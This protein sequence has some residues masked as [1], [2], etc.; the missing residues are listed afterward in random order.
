M[1]VYKSRF[2]SRA[3]V[4]F[5]ETPD[6]ARVDWIYYR[7]RSSPL[8]K[9]RWRP[10]QTV[11]I[12]LQKTPTEL[13]AMMETRTASRIAAAQ[14]KDGLRCRRCDSKDARVLDEVEKMWNQFALAQKTPLLERGWFEEMSKAGALDVVAASDPAGNLLA[15]HLV[16][17]T[18][19]RARQLIAISP[20]KPLPSVAWRNAVSRANCLIHWH[21]FLSFREQGIREFDFGGWYPG[22]TDIRLLGINR[23]KMSLGGRVVSEYDGEEPMTVKG[24]VLLTAAHL[25][26]RFRRTHSPA[27]ADSEDKDHV[28]HLE[29]HKVSP[30]F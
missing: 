13:M 17:L 15:Y 18:T 29:E 14:E 8:A 5:D 26:A 1:F 30:A 2:L 16:L 6:G 11:L 19:K 12:D 21:N 24:W 10:F 22:T 28:A 9:S 3:E 20:Y 4:W 25:L 23:F 7:Q 27:R